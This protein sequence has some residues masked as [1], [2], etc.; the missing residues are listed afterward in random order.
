M[1]T[2]TTKTIKPDGTGDYQTLAAW[3]AARKGNLVTGD[4]IE[5]AECYGGG[6]LGDTD[7]LATDWTTDATHYI[8]IYVADGQKHAGTYDS[9]KARIGDG[10]DTK[11]LYITAGYVY[12][13][14]LQINS[15]LGAGGASTAYAVRIGGSATTVSNTV[16]ERCL[17]K[18]AD[19]PLQF[20]TR[21][22]ATVR[23]CWIWNGKRGGVYAWGDLSTCTLKNCTVLNTQAV[24]N[25]YTIITSH[26]GMTLTEEN[27]YFNAYN[28]GIYWQ[29]A[30][31]LNKG[32]HSATVNAEATTAA[33]RNIAY[34]TSTFTSVT[35]GSEDVHLVPGSGLLLQAD[36]LSATFTDDYEGTT[37]PKARWD[38]GADQLSKALAG[39]LFI[40]GV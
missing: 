11:S 2:I 38:I 31:T 39:A 23:N 37:R 21:S 12:V 1:A 15:V 14:D 32:S 8:E 24:T 3:V 10:T 6:D 17:I 33:L 4:K 36:D 16:M 25:S 28:S 40:L 9:N 29:N 30:G 35:A 26:A 13:R 22:A 20:Y 7:I 5:R 27:N 34:D 18:G 19:F